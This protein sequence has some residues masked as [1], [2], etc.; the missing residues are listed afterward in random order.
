MDGVDFGRKAYVDLMGSKDPAIKRLIDEGY[1]F[2][3][4][5]FKP[6]SKPAALRVKDSKGVASE[7][8]QQGYLTETCPAYNELGDPIQVMQSVWRKRKETG[9]T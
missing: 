9:S 8:A 2:V 7:L 5:A 3:T 1:E 6:E 4:N